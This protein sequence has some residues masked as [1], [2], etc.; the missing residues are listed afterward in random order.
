MRKKKSI[1]RNGSGYRFY[2]APLHAIVIVRT[3]IVAVIG[4]AVFWFSFSWHERQLLAEQ[5]IKY[6]AELMPY[7]SSLA[8][9]L[10]ERISMLNGIEAFV[11]TSLRD[12]DLRNRF[13]IFA[14]GLYT[15]NSGIR[16]IQVF[17]PTGPE[18]LY[19]VAR[20]EAVATG[21]LKNLLQDQR[22]GV[23]T[24]IDAAIATGR[25]MLSG[26]YELRQGGLGLV[27][28]RALY[29]RGSFWGL[30]V[31]VLDMPSLLKQS[32][33]DP[34]ASPRL[35][36]GLNDET[37]QTFVGQASVFNADPIIIDIDIA[38]QTWRL[39]GSPAGGWLSTYKTSLRSFQALGLFTAFLLVGLVYSLSNQGMRLRDSVDKKTAALRESEGKLK[40]AQRLGRIGSWEYDLEMKRIHWSDEVYVLYGRAPTLG[41]P[42]LEEGASYYSP[43]TVK[44]LRELTDIAATEGKSF[45]YD[46]QAKLPDGSITYFSWSVR[47]E[48]D[49]SGRI[50][51]LF[52]TVQ[53]IAERKKAEKEIR[54][55][56]EGLEEKV[57][58]RTAQLEAANK[59]L[60]AFTYSV[61]H[62]LRAPL[63]AI[64]G[65]SRILVEDYGTKLD[66]EGRRIC[67]VISRSAQNMGALIDD[68]LSFSRLGRTSLNIGS[69]DMALMAR[70][71][72]M[73]ITSPEEKDHVDFTIEELPLA[74]ADPILIKQVW[75]N[76]LS[77]AVK[78]SAKKTRPEI[79]VGAVAGAGEII[80]SV[81]DNGAG[82]DMNYADKL[83][84]VFQRLHSASEFDGTG[85]GLAIVKR[86]VILHG[87]R[88]W[89]ESEP[90]KG[91]TFYFSIKKGD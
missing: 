35:R 14:E 37:G 27:A 56:N 70:S 24:D 69:V 8:T 78:F 1:A 72:F 74:E 29:D 21:T 50:V 86:I 23:R 4:I 19:P 52:G 2:S 36:I 33:I 32:G 11:Q 48:R 91:A 28:R 65:F 16:A 68:L 43:E 51:K 17:P 9:T 40:E 63:R 66:E 26:P 54:K 53:D 60:E 10:N 42:S 84:G 5:K 83:F 6:H 58:E 39:A 45:F 76:L 22:P 67:S 75:A 38:G 64:N 87:G 47:A 25:T 7:A 41:P 18:M 34:P 12:A 3:V 30:A 88:T 89:A 15:A 13:K 46:F 81:R 62:D 79:R 82:F 90:E 71:V 80:Y 59:E 49:E 31:I 77:N 20:N 44:K 55:L 61:S 85:V 73:E 57:N